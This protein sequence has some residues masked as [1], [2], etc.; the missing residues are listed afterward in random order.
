MTEKK[1]NIITNIVDDGPHGNIN[2]YTISFLTP[3]NI[4][5]LKYTD[6]KAFKVHN[7]YNSYEIAT[8][9]AKEIKNYQSIHDVYVCQMGKIYAWDDVSRSESMEYDDEKLNDLEKTRKQNE[10]KVK[11]MRETFKN[12][13]KTNS[14]AVEKTKADIV[15]KRLHRKLYQK[16]K[17]TKSEYEKMTQTATVSDS[18][19][20]RKA[21]D[22]VNK[23]METTNECDYLLENPPSALKYGCITIF[24]PKKI[25][26]LQ[27][28]CY[29]LRGL[30]E[31]PEKLRRRVNELQE[32]Y[33][34]DTVHTFEVGKWS[35]FSETANNDSGYMLKLLNYS[36][37]CYID[38]IESERVEFGKHQEQ[39]KTNSDKPANGT[40]E[41]IN[42][43]PSLSRQT[44]RKNARSRTKKTNKTGLT[45]KSAESYL[46]PEH[47][48][49]ID[50]IYNIIN[51]PELEGRYSN[52][53]NGST[54][55]Q[56]ESIKLDVGQDN[57]LE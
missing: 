49:D 15:R 28:L 35:A 40:A 23:E 42:P 4:E 12:E 17:I 43:N 20:V 34:E 5:K 1:Y 54:E 55:T 7:G 37:K 51:D 24:S 36:M 9:N 48:E 32:I 46:A 44:K 41:I 45:N 22:L 39:L 29:K 18:D 27:T 19:T 21:M 50:N 8:S 53:S 57:R 3:Q 14:L 56:S 38:N 26:G 30:Y 13:F 33:Q 31:T 10:D 6:I 25:G 16:G 47:K 11:L 2:W 52:Y